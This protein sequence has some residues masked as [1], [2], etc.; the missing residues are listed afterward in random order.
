[1]SKRPLLREFRATR[2]N[3][4]LAV[5]VQLVATNPSCDWSVQE[6]PD[7]TPENRHV[8]LTLGDN[9]NQGGRYGTSVAPLDFTVSRA[10]STQS[11]RVTV[12]RPQTAEA[13]YAVPIRG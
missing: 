13:T 7:S 12:R 2:R 1:M 8:A 10:D 11:L 5:G 4:S 6:L 3:G 9:V